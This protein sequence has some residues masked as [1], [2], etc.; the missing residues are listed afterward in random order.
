MSIMRNLRRRETGQ[1][2]RHSAIGSWINLL[3]SDSDVTQ[4]VEIGTWKGGGSTELIRAG[5]YN[6]DSVSALCLEADYDMFCESEKRHRNTR[7]ITVLWGSVVNSSQ[8]DRTDLN[9]LEKGWIDQDEKALHRCPNVLEQIY[10]KIDL[11]LL[12][13]GE[14][15]TYSDW[16]ILHDRLS[17]WVILDDTATRKSRRIQNEV[18]QGVWPFREVWHSSERNGVSILLKKTQNH[19]LKA[20]DEPPSDRATCRHG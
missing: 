8:L 6:R 10:P 1:I 20:T 3:C 18:R 5:I 19:L 12:D 4:I 14:F 11:L 13:G 2:T 17:K 7:G 15:S 9:D 16:L